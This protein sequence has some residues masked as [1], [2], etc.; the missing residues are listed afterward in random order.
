VA[1]DIGER[2]SRSE[3][4]DGIDLSGANEHDE[5]D[6]TH[7]DDSDSNSDDEGDYDDEYDGDGV[8]TQED[9]D[10]IDDGPVED[11]VSSD[12]AEEFEQGQNSL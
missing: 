12:E 6:P 9:L 7:P 8:P 3:Y 1:R 2:L 4:A 11:G 10:F 5:E